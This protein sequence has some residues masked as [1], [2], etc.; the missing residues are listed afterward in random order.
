V[1]LI[2]LREARSLVFDACPTIEA[3]HLTLRDALGSV[4]AEAVLAVDSVPPFDNSAMD[5]Y[6][7]RSADTAS[8]PVRLRVA[9]TTF[10]GDDE[11]EF[12]APGTS[13]RV[14]TGAPIPSGA[15]AVCMVELTRQTAPDEVEISV[16]L[17]T[18][19]QVR[20]AGEDVATGE[21]C[22][23]PGTE[24]SPAHI[25]VLVSAGVTAVLAVPKPRVGV[26]STGDELVPEGAPLVRGKIR[27][28]NRPALLT[29]LS[30]DGFIPVDLG[31]SSD[32]VAALARAIEAGARFC[33]AVITIG[34][35]SVG[36]HDFLAD[37]L[38]KLGADPAASLQMAIRPAKPFAFGVLP[39][40]RAPI[41]GLPGN[42]VSA[43]VS[44]ELIVRPALRSMSGHE[45]VDRPVLSAVVPDGISRSP[46]GKTHFVRV[47]LHRR[48]N[49]RVEVAPVARQG[50]HQLRG[51]ADA[52][53][54]AIVRDG[55]GIVAGGLVDVI[56]LRDD[57]LA[58]ERDAQWLP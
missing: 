7:L 34:G 43:L 31:T 35:V 2:G 26:L 54:L 36:E 52:E 58:P 10:A 18:G 25:G 16:A 50:S 32:D 46:D 6:A 3:A 21:V 56:V 30:E 14:M 9:G 41:F 8:P 5:G 42:P 45:K 44:Y 19:E 38:V 47:R 24:L 53:A 1:A 20:R 29:R 51:L 49:G 37:A 48:E 28:S 55:S 13:E 17:Q 4:L 12:L 39:E 57:A 27:D 11:A 23:P 33:D 22:F 40:A 15:D